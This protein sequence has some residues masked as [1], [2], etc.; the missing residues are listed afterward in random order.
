MAGANSLA[1][2]KDRQH[3]FQCLTEGGL[4][5]VEDSSRRVIKNEAG[6]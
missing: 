5:T 6:G 1:S 3:I 4:A 2:I